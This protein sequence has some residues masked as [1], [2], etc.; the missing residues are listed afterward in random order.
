M[1]QYEDRNN[2]LSRNYELIVKC[3][4]KTFQR[5]YWFK[6]AKYKYSDDAQIAKLDLSALKDDLTQHIFEQLCKLDF[7]KLKKLDDEHKLINYVAGIANMS[8]RLIDTPFWKT[9]IKSFA[10]SADISKTIIC[11]DVDFE[12]PQKQK[13]VQKTTTQIYNELKRVCKSDVELLFADKIDTLIFVVNTLPASDKNILLQYVANDCNLTK[14]LKQLYKSQRVRR[15][16]LKLDK[17][18]LYVKIN[19]IIESVKTKYEKQ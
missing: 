7:E 12:K 19:S 10:N 16:W 15:S 1:S 9:Y 14:T 17:K 5:Q 18:T 4:N 11:S 8:L 3:I 13:K 2:I 6:C